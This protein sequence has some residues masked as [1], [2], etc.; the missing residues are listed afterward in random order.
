MNLICDEENH[1]SFDVCALDENRRWR[2]GKSQS[3]CQG[4]RNGVF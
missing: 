3:S 4:G 1:S 2:K